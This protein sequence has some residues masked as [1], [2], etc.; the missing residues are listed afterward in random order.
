MTDEDDAAIVARVRSGEV[1]AFSV[2]VRRHGDRA[3]RFARRF[4]GDH[5]DA[6]DA[7]QEAFVR[8]YQGIARYQERQRFGA[9]LYGILVNECRALARRRRRHATRFLSAGDAAFDVAAPERHAPQ[10]SES[11]DAAIARLPDALREAFLLRHVEEL[12]YAE[13]QAATGVGLSALKMRV[14]R[15]CDALRLQLEDHVRD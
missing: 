5:V 8:A 2:L 10:L 14:K 3:M 6:E 9:W 12:D 1:D 11:L 15:A 7:V 13:M 4:L